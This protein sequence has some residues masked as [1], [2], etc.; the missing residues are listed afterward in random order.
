[1]QTT[2]ASTL[3]AGRAGMLA[4]N[5]PNDIHS[6]I[7]TDAVR[8]GLLAQFDTSY[9]HVG[10]ALSPGKAKLIAALAVDAVSILATGGAGAVT[11]QTLTSA[12]FN[13]V[14]VGGSGAKMSPA[15]RVTM[16]LNSHANW[17]LTDAYISGF[18]TDGRPLREALVVPDGGNVTLTT[19]NFFAQVTE[20]YLPAQAGTA[21]TFTVGVSADEGEFCRRDSGVVIYNPHHEAYTSDDGYTAG[22]VFG[23]LLRGRI[24]VPVEGTVAD[25]D[26]AFVRTA[27]ASTNIR[28]QWKSGP[29][30]NFTQLP[31]AWFRSSNTDGLAILELL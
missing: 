29:A 9:P 8:N 12:A 13:G 25:G 14:G 7:A 26:A 28:G 27:T 23:L 5:G 31:N 6:K 4:D 16:T 11:A 24:W 15:R 21:A 1:M 10:G 30:A 22:D 19:K 18:G 3:R 17:D 20:I 2:Y